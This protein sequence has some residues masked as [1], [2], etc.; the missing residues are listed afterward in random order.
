[1]RNLMFALVAIIGG[2]AFLT[3][4]SHASAAPVPD[5]GLEFEEDRWCTDAVEAI[6]PGTGL[7]KWR[8]GKWKTEQYDYEGETRVRA[9]FAGLVWASGAGGVEAVCDQWCQQAP[10]ECTSMGLG[11]DGHLD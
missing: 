7:K 4:A 5:W 6:Y 1:M 3:P 8:C 9:R 10:G 11:G 2:L